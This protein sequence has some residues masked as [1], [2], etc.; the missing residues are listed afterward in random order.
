MPPATER[1]RARRPSRPKGS[2]KLWVCGQEKVRLA[3]PPFQPLPT[4]PTASLRPSRS[5][6]PPLRVA[7]ARSALVERKRA[8][9]GWVAEAVVRWGRRPA[10]LE[11]I[12][13]TPPRRQRAPPTPATPP[14]RGLVVHKLRVWVCIVSRGA[15]RASGACRFLSP[16]HPL[17]LRKSVTLRAVLPGPQHLPKTLERAS[18]HAHSCSEATRKGRRGQG[19]NS[20][21]VFSLRVLSAPKSV[22]LFGRGRVS[23]H[24]LRHLWLV[25]VLGGTHRL[26]GTLA[27]AH[28]LDPR[29]KTVKNNCKMKG[30]RGSSGCGAERWRKRPTNGGRFPP[31]NLPPPTNKHCHQYMPNPS[32]LGSLSTAHAGTPTSQRSAPAAAR[33]ATTLRTPRGNASGRH[34]PGGTVPSSRAVAK[35]AV[36]VLCG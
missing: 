31:Q 3:R 34:T 29:P 22:F 8:A 35:A 32:L 7:R 23:H 12:H 18:G 1:A 6:P 25:R 24:N 21:C 17:T 20:G 28:P 9:G 16:S 14:A 30:G 19:G 4:A 15:R 10:G 5:T 27:H 2:H 26:W 13:S 33:L 11:A 36:Q